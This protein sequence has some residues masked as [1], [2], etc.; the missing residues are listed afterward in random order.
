MPPPR[1]WP[2][3]RASFPL[4]QSSESS[5]NLGRSPAGGHGAGRDL[6]PYLRCRP[7]QGRDPPKSPRLPA[8]QQPGYQALCMT[9]GTRLAP[10]IAFPEMGRLGGVH[11]PSQN[12]KFCHQTYGQGHPKKDR[13]H[14]CSH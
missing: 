5:A 11:P 4:S 1:P 2:R 13:C 7:A 8:G 6:L 12:G 3:P 14:H 10:C 9:P